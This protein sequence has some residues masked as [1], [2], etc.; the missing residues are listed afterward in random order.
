MLRTQHFPALLLAVITMLGV[1]ACDGN[2]GGP[3]A[4]T[5]V[6]ESASVSLNTPNGAEGAVLVRLVGPGYSNIQ[7]ANSGYRIFWRRQ[8][9]EEVRVLV[10][11]SIAPGPLFTADVSRS[12]RGTYTAALVEVAARDD[13]MRESVAGYSVEMSFAPR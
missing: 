13:A 1:V 3:T 8:S 5:I 10:V 4:P 12:S 11:G 9:E 2:S 7:P 6:N